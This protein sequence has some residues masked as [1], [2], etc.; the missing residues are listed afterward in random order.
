MMEQN[1]VHEHPV[2]EQGEANAPPW[3]L[4]TFGQNN[5]ILHHNTNILS[6]YYY[7]YFQA[8]DLLHTRVLNTGALNPLVSHRAKFQ[9]LQKFTPPTNSSADAFDG[10]AY[11]C[12][13]LAP[14]LQVNF[15]IM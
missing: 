10:V 4:Q 15:D 5:N 11:M 2:R 13:N 12:R 1:C 9:R 6:N 7:Y 8:L 3:I 14:A